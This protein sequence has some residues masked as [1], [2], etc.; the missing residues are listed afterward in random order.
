MGAFSETIV[1]GWF[2]LLYR[3]LAESFHQSSPEMMYNQLKRKRTR[4][5]LNHPSLWF[6]IFQLMQK[7]TIFGP[8]FP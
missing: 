5:S 1:S 6:W 3:I 7:Q 8:L 2:Y 4:I